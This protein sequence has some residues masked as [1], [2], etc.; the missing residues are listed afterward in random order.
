[1][2]SEFPSMNVLYRDGVIS[3]HKAIHHI[4]WKNKKITIIANDKIINGCEKKV[5]NEITNAG[6]Q[7]EAFEVKKITN[8]DQGIF[9]PYFGHESDDLT[10]M[11]SLGYVKI[12]AEFALSCGI[13][14]E[15]LDRVLRIDEAGKGKLIFDRNVLTYLSLGAIDRVYEYYK[16]LLEPNYPTHTVYP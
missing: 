2:L 5:I 15:A 12:A 7:Y 14:R 16:P 1:M 3:S 13:A 8:I 10:N 11:L 6:E 9:V 4:D